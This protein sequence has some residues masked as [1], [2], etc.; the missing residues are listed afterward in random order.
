MEITDGQI[1]KDEIITFLAREL[2]AAK[3]QLA[4]YVPLLE[5]NSDLNKLLEEIKTL[6][7]ENV[8]LRMK[9]AERGIE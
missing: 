1:D 3:E 9:I 4:F 6:R 8:T 2:Q 5:H 7:I